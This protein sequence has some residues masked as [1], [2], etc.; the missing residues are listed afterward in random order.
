VKLREQEIRNM[1]WM[2]NMIIMDRRDRMDDV[3]PI[4]KPRV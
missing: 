1:E 4:F 2:S 3:V